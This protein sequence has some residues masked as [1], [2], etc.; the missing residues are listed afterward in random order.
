MI[1]RN[2]AEDYLSGKIKDED[3][4]K[5]ENILLSMLEEIKEKT[6]DLYYEIES[7]SEI[8]L[9]DED[10]DKINTK[11]INSKNK[12]IK[13]KY[14]LY[15]LNTIFVLSGLF[16]LFYNRKTVKE[17]TEETLKCLE[18]YYFKPQKI[19]KSDAWVFK[20]HRKPIKNFFHLDIEKK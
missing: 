9:S 12:K 8:K 4:F 7:K 16:I 11:I 15:G 14:I 20:S 3:Q 17:Q 18:K 5:K 13:I 6:D 19:E 10:I 1:F 2:V